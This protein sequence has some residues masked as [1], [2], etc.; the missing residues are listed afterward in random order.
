[1]KV[2][3]KLAFTMMS[4]K[5][6]H[7]KVCSRISDR[8]LDALLVHTPENICYL[9]GFHTPGYY[10]LQFLIVIPGLD[11]IILLRALEGRGVDAYCWFGSENYLGYGDDENPLVSVAGLLERLGLSNR[12][13]R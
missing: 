3:K 12:S 2:Q 9:S 8:A 7:R 6:R 11:P 10:Y 13:G 5:S 4:Q 1:M